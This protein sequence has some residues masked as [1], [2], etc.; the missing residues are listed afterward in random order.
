MA[1]SDDLLSTIH[2]RT[3]EGKI[4]WSSLSNTGFIAQIGDNAITLDRTGPEIVLRITN[5]E[6]TVI[7]SSSSLRRA[8]SIIEQIYEIARRKALKI[9]ETLSSLNS[10]LTKSG[11]VDSV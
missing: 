2:Q 10:P 6:N 5:D 1:V 4:E 3:V 9:D 8:D 7:E 11:L